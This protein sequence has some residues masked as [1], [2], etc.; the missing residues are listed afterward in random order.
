[1]LKEIILGL[2]RD[3]TTSIEKVQDIMNN[4]DSKSN[5]VYIYSNFKTLNHSIIQLETSG[6][7]FHHSIQIVQDGKNKIKNRIG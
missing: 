4:Y 7:S 2:N 1:M 3:D 5:L 6:L